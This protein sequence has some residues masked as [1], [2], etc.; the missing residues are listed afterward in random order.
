MSKE[1]II[2]YEG[3]L[4]IHASQAAQKE[5]ALQFIGSIP[6][7]EYVAHID[8]LISKPETDSEI[9]VRAAIHTYDVV[10]SDE[11]RSYLPDRSPEITD[12][13][14][15]YYRSDVY[16][17]SYPQ[18][19]IDAITAKIGQVPTDLVIATNSHIDNFSPNSGYRGMLTPELSYWAG[20]ESNPITKPDPPCGIAR[21]EIYRSLLRCG[22]NP[23]KERVCDSSHDNS[24]RPDNKYQTTFRRKGEV[25]LSA[26]S[27]DLDRWR[28]N[29]AAHWRDILREESSVNTDAALFSSGTSSAEAIMLALS[30]RT[31]GE[32]YIHPYWYYENLPTG[33]RLLNESPEITEDTQIVLVNLEPTNFFT[34]D[35]TQ[36]IDDPIQTLN[37]LAEMCRG[38]DDTERY[39]VIDV[40]VDPLFQAKDHIDGDIPDNLH[41]VKTLSASKHQRGGRK[42]FFGAAYTNDRDLSIEIE[43]ARASVG[44]DIY[45]SHIV[46][47]PRPSAVWLAHQRDT[48][49]NLNEMVAKSAQ[50]TSES[51]WK[52]KPHTYHTFFFPPDEVLEGI[53]TIGVKNGNVEDEVKRFNDE[54]SKIVE[55]VVKEMKTP[56]IDIGDS[57]GLP[58]TRVCTQGGFNELN[59]VRFRLKL[60]RI[61]PGYDTSPELVEETVERLLAKLSESH[62]RIMNSLKR[63]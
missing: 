43:Q 4:F 41:I 62:A 59:G 19:V 48:V 54:V 58:Q 40:T 61:C 26:T 5:A 47:F 30:E 32:T 2:N 37:R 39:A 44:G 14:S 15:V 1:R 28:L 29:S 9:A 21:Q 8:N 63:S 31:S 53:Q 38:D 7:Q 45:E 20:T 27:E 16:K 33:Q 36:E 51:E 55:E 10:V 60:P 49:R 23:L 11:I 17:Q 56:Y 25:S 34:F 13:A 12:A 46:H 50:E 57:F 52:L 42:Y 24:A 22:V 6:K 3:S 18:S 35:E